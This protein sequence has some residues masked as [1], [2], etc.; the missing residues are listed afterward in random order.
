MLLV[1]CDAR[2][3]LI[4]A[5]ANDALPGV[6]WQQWRT[7]ELADLVATAL[8]RKQSWVATVV[9]TVVDAPARHRRGGPVSPG[10]RGAGWACAQGC[11]G[12]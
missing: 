12:S 11:Q 1:T 5:I 4:E 8:T 9:R 2:R 6:T 7:H 3:C 10:P